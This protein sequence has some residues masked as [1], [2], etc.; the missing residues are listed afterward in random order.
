M[1]IIKILPDNLIN[2]IAAGEVVNRPY[3][4]LK[5]LVENSVDAKSSEII[6]KIQN[7]G[8]DLLE[9][10][11]NGNGM[12]KNDLILAFE[13]HATSKIKDYS[14]LENISTMGFRGEAL[15]SIAAVSKVRCSSRPV[16]ASEEEANVIEIIGGKILN[17]KPIAI[18]NSTTMS[19]EKIFYNVPAR[20]KFLKDGKTEYRYI[21][22]YLKKAALAY[23]EMSFKFFSDNR[24]VFEYE[25]DNLKNRIK[26]VFKEVPEDALLE[27]NYQSDNYHLTGFVGKKELARR[28]RDNQ[29]LF[30]NNRPVENKVINYAIFQAFKGLIE[31]GYYPF[32]VLHLT[33]PVN[34][35]DVNI[36]PNK[37]EV[38]FQNENLIRMLVKNSIT[39]VLAGQTSLVSFGLNDY[40]DNQ[41]TAEKE[42]Y[43]QTKVNRAG[44]N[45]AENENKQINK[46]IGKDKELFSYEDKS[47]SDYAKLEI[48]NSVE[49]LQIEEEKQEDLFLRREKSGVDLLRLGREQ[50][51]TESVW[52]LHNKYIILESESGMMII[53]QHVAQER[54]LYEK[55]LSWMSESKNQSQIL[56]FPVR[57]E[58]SPE[59]SFI[60]QDIAEHLA[61]LGYT[62]SHFGGQSYV[63]EGIP[64]GVKNGEEVADL[65]AILDYYKKYREEK[66]GVMDSLAASY[67]CKR[68]IKAGQNLQRSEMLELIN[69]LFLCKFP[70]VCPHGR[71][72]IIN[73]T[74]KDLDKRFMRSN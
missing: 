22:T 70:H 51:V 45:A 73:I 3:S 20:R 7:G 26:D 6:V 10:S 21:Y 5:E 40:K 36:H 52:Q 72:V 66:M 24:Q 38:K 15:P 18:T 27:V 61:K 42:F 48:T 2:K 16:S 53:D 34:E 1:S 65:K 30:I 43:G 60:Y 71:P 33:M 9:I 14:D 32:F 63:I 62:I 29:Y 13:R 56:L 41:S 55:A 17:V 67:A 39:E 54:I 23:P 25:K 64:A 74:V 50:V 11:D 68:S 59:D 31:S 37:L 19:I 47:A 28:T 35:V 44:L 57:I 8:K 58:L 69:Q 12:S 4:V 49:K 46:T